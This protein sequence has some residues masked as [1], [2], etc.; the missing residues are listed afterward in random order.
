[1]PENAILTL[2]WHSS[3]LGITFL[4]AL[5]TLLHHF[6]FA[7]LL[8]RHKMS[9]QSAYMQKSSQAGLGEFAWRWPWL[10]SRTL[11]L[12]RVPSMPGTK[13][14]SLCLC[15][16]YEP[17]RRKNK[18]LCHQTQNNAASH[19]PGVLL[20]WHTSLCAQVTSKHHQNKM[21]LWLLFLLWIIKDLLLWC[22]PMLIAALLIIARHGSNLDVHQQMNG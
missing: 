2:P 12:R 4:R 15:Y 14:N 18:M 8:L 21:L 13:S 7:A 17:P 22:T 6:W 3:K 19:N 11:D 10:A 9:F 20:L 16:L 1:M 5:K